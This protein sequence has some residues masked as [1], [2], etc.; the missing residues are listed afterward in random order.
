MFLLLLYH[1]KKPHGDVF[2]FLV[3]GQVARPEKLSNAQERKRE[4]LK[5]GELAK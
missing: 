5:L 2:K 1:L 4:M 3:T